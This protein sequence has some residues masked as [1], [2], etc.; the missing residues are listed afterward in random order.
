MPM[1]IAG[2]AAYALL[3]WRSEVLWPWFAGFI[4]VRALVVL[5]L[6]SWCGIRLAAPWIGRIPDGLHVK[7]YLALL[8]AV[9]VVMLLA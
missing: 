6:G 9:L 4:D 8:S 7:C 3:A 1:A 2:T 5:V